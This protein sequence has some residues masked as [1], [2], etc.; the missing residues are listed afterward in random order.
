MDFMKTISI[1]V[2]GIFTSS[3]VHAFMAGT[4]FFQPDRDTVLIGVNQSSRQHSGFYQWLDGYLAD[5][6]KHLNHFLPRSLGHPRKWVVFLSPMYRG[7]EHP[8]G[9]YGDLYAPSCSR[10][11]DSSYAGFMI[12]G[13]IKRITKAADIVVSIMTFFLTAWLYLLPFPILLNSPVLF[14]IS[15]KTPSE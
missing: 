1:L 2:P 15:Y 8:S 14:G 9:D 10:L 6:G 12:F 3:A 4:P 5:I 13:G 11:Q 7:H